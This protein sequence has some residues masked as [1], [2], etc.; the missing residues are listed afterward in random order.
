M[1]VCDEKKNLIRI[2]CYSILSEGQTT[3]SH[4][5]NVGFPALFA[6]RRQISGHLLA[7]SS[8]KNQT[9]LDTFLATLFDMLHSAFF[10]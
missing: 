6:S 10:Y 9:D 8:I 5:A 3:N 1:K 4:S 7:S 2:S